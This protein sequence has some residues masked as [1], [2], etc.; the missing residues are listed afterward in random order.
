MK[1]IK[2]S[3]DTQRGYLWLQNY[4]TATVYIAA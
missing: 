3:L 1:L 2:F 4:I